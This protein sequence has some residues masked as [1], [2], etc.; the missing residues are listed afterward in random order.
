MTEVHGEV[1]DDALAPLRELLER[2]ATPQRNGRR[3]SNGNGGR[4][5]G[6]GNGGGGGS[7]GGDDG[8]PDF[9]PFIRVMREGFDRL[10]DQ[11]QAFAEQLV[12]TATKPLVA[13][14][15]DLAG[16]NK[17]LAQSVGELAARVHALE[18]QVAALK[19]AAAEKGSAP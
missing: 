6:G 18:R 15:T 5:N 13:L 10:S 11:Q 4:G 16:Q 7:G 3:D 2:A 17:S 1:L 19:P 8:R 9:G 12:D 14:I